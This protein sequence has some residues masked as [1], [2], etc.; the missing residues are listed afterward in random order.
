METVKSA[1][2][3]AREYLLQQEADCFADA[4]NDGGKGCFIITFRSTDGRIA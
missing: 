2:V 3:I 1:K 4:R